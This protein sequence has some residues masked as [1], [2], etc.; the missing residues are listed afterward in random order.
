MECSKRNCKEKK[1]CRITC[2][3]S[4]RVHSPWRVKEEND[5]VGIRKKMPQH[6]FF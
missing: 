1:Q 2:S 4:G 3:I 6:H 5:A